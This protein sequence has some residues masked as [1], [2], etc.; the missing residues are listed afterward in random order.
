MGK[1]QSL[2]PLVLDKHRVE[3]ALPAGLF[4]AQQCAAAI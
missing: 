3:T 4:H 1:G 2:A